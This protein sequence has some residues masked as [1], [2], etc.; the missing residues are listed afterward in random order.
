MEQ[1]GELFQL[2]T[3]KLESDQREFTIMKLEVMNFLKNMKID[4]DLGALFE[5]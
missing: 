1:F 3:I 2:V 4:F 5:S